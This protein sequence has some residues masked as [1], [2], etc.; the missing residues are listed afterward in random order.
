MLYVINA[1]AFIN[2]TAL[3]LL[4]QPIRQGERT[5]FFLGWR[6]R[7]GRR[8]DPHRG[9]C[10][11]LLRCRSAGPWQRLGEREHRVLR[12]GGD[13]PSWGLKAT[14]RESRHEPELAHTG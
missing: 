12:G 6:N 2:R 4:I 14:H 9:V 8:A 7:I 10:R 3:S 11:P 13:L 1:V 5:A